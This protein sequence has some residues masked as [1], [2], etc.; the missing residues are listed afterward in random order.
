M[1]TSHILLILCVLI[2]I[3]ALAFA[4]DK[5][6]SKQKEKRIVV[7]KQAGSTADYAVETKD[8]K[9]LVLKCDVSDDLC[10]IICIEA[11]SDLKSD[12]EDIF[13]QAD[14]MSSAKAG[15]KLPLTLEY[16]LYKNES[17]DLKLFE[18]YT[19][20]GKEWKKAGLVTVEL[21][22]PGDESSLKQKIK[23]KMDECENQ[24][25]NCI[26]LKG[27]ECDIKCETAGTEKKVIIK[28]KGDGKEE[29]DFVIKCKPG[30]A[31]GM[32]GKNCKKLVF[33]SD[34]GKAL[35]PDKCMDE[36]KKALKN[37]ED[38]DEITSITIMQCDDCLMITL[39]DEESGVCG[40]MAGAYAF[41]KAEGGSGQ[42]DFFKDFDNKSAVKV[43]VEGDEDSKGLMK[44]Y[45]GSCCEDNMKEMQ[46]KLKELQDMLK[47]IQDIDA[48]TQERLNQKVQ[49]LDGVMKKLDG[50]MQEI[51]K[52][53]Q[54][55]SCPQIKMF[56]DFDE[57]D[58]KVLKDI[59][60]EQIQ[61]FFEQYEDDDDEDEESET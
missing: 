60:E 47:T 16:R 61:K 10:K 49:K 33:K 8:G 31:L 7:K 23:L 55:M 5:D 53:M 38:A 24:D 45:Q 42:F 29:E 17:G 15:N 1:R 36:I 52:K 32:S 37:F 12:M 59:D 41:G 54:S 20:V 13:K 11:A 2:L 27:G 48:S 25:S 22:K 6:S 46:G 56:G 50:L 3:P 57:E 4:A 9:I 39:G 21:T 34:D 19:D 51:E 30:T 35:S 44:M 28:K 18:P 40:G 26:M 43:L 14:K 58:L